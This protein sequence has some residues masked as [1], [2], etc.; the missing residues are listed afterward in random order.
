MEKKYR[1]EYLLGVVKKHLESVN[2]SV[3]RLA[4]FLDAEESLNETR[5]PGASI[6]SCSILGD[7]IKEKERYTCECVLSHV[8]YDF[9]HWLQ[10]NDYSSMTS[11]EVVEQI[12]KILD[13]IAL[14]YDYD[15]DSDR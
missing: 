1:S 2:L 8:F 12:K 9:Y 10:S 6:K 11:L 4:G 15:F 7:F 3:A 5:D 13:E 14:F